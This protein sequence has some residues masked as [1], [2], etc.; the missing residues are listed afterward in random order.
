MQALEES[1]KDFV[2]LQNQPLSTFP[3][4]GTLAL[5]HGLKERSICAAY[6]VKKRA[7]NQ[8]A[9]RAGL[10]AG[11]GIGGPCIRLHDRHLVCEQWLEQMRGTMQQ[12][13]QSL[14]RP[15]CFVRA[16]CDAVHG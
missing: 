12:A 3:K 7:V 8:A 6:T 11:S 5:I 13:S 14:C 10:L 15:T 16:A 4:Q 9:S 2:Q 1:P